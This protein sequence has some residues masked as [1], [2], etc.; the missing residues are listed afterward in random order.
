MKNTQRDITS[1]VELTTDQ[2]IEL[3][4]DLTERWKHR[5]SFVWSSFYKLVIY[6]LTIISLPA[7]VYLQLKDT[8]NNY[9]ILLLFLFS[10]LIM[11]FIWINSKKVFS[12]IEQEDIRQKIVLEHARE[13]YKNDF[14]INIYPQ[15]SNDTNG[16]ITMMTGF[17]RSMILLYA[18]FVPIMMIVLFL[19]LG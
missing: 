14:G 5:H 13:L 8:H 2:K 18:I 4:N 19:E 15:N 17:V 7:I 1:K 11:L 16:V 12:Y 6:Q 10:F 3:L 9:V